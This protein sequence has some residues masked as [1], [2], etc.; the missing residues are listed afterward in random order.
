MEARKRIPAVDRK[1][2]ILVSSLHVFA[3]RGFD[4]A[5][6]KDLAKAAGV[7]EALLYRHFPTKEAIYNDLVTL[8]GS[9]KEV[10]IRRLTQDEPSTAAFVRT[11]FVLARVIILGQPGRP[12]DVSIDRLMGQSLL[13]DGAFAAAI[14]DSLFV[15][16]V[17]YLSQC[18]D[19]ARESGEVEGRDA[20]PHRLC[21]LFHHF[22]GA[23]ALYSLPKTPLLPYDDADQMLHDVVRFAFRGVGFTETALD[24]HL[25]FARLKSE[26]ASLLK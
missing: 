22:L 17:P 2:E 21:F 24:I 5:T 26:C 16:M 23:I 4:G 9:T 12:K 1:H 20:S 13:G 10:V 15:P 19:L 6:T 11:F 8:L 18:L 14:L 3:Q 25:D 7:S